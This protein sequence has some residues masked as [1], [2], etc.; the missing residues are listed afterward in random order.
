MSNDS[1]KY[2]YTYFFWWTSVLWIYLTTKYRNIGINEYFWNHN[3]MK[4]YPYFIVW[5]TCLNDCFYFFFFGCYFF[6][7]YNMYLTIVVNAFRWPDKRSN[8]LWGTYSNKFYNHFSILMHIYS[9]AYRKYRFLSLPV[10]S[11]INRTEGNLSA[12]LWECPSSP[13]LS[14]GTGWI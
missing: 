7:S 13:W 9:W 4:E 6:R 14:P 1:I 8:S 5:Y 2:I 11:L 3:K 12:D 10:R